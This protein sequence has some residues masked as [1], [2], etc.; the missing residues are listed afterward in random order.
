MS[1]AKDSAKALSAKAGQ[2]CFS[3]PQHF[4]K[5]TIPREDQRQ[6][7][8]KATLAGNKVANRYLLTSIFLNSYENVATTGVSHIFRN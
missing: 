5:M 2:R 8:L 7:G 4:H 3:K 6:T 1:F